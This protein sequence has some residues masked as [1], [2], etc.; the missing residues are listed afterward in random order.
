[1]NKKKNDYKNVVRNF[2]TKG[3]TKEALNFLLKNKIDEEQS[4]LLSARFLNLQKKIIK[5]VIDEKEANIEFNKVNESILNIIKA[6]QSTI[7]DKEKK[8]DD[9]RVNRGVKYIVLAACIVIGVSF[10]GYIFFFKNI[11]SKSFLLSSQPL[12]FSAE[13][14]ALKVLILPFKPDINSNDLHIDYKNQIKES[15]Q[16]KSDKEKLNVKLMVLDN[17]KFPTSDIEA[18]EVGETFKADIVIWGNFEENKL[19]PSGLRIRY[20]IIKETNIVSNRIIGDTEMQPLSNLRQIREGYLLN[21][22]DFI[23][24]WIEVRNAYR[25]GDFKSS[26]SKLNRILELIKNDTLEVETY[27]QLGQFYYEFNRG[28]DALK[29]F[30]KALA[31]QTTYLSP[32]HIDLTQTYASIC[33]AYNRIQNYE[34]AIFYCNKALEVQNNNLE[35]IEINPM[36]YRHL[37][38]LYNNKGDNKNAIKHHKKA[39]KV[40]EAILNSDEKEIARTYMNIGISFSNSNNDSAIFYIKKAM[41]IQYIVLDSLHPDLG[42]NYSNLASRLIIKGEYK[43]SYICYLEALRIQSEVLDSLHP[44]LASTYIGLA[45]SLMYQDTREFKLPLKYLQKALKIQRVTLDSLHPYLARTYINLG[46]LYS[47]KNQIDTS[48]IYYKRALNVQLSSLDSMHSDFTITYSSIGAILG[49]KKDYKSALKYL[50]KALEIQESNGLSSQLGI[51][52]MNIGA[53]ILYSKSYNEDEAL[54]YFDEA[55]NIFSQYPDKINMLLLD[56]NYS[57]YYLE[58][59]QFEK[60]LEL[61][62]KT[63]PQLR[64][65]YSKDH[66]NLIEAIEILD[67]LTLLTN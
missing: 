5:G 49:F 3:Q 35:P 29:C 7:T 12:P 26:I 11:N 31:A 2:I 41:E 4:V 59:C 40:Q 20:A 14:T 19:G 30:E 16:V 61:I 50:K 64:E 44:E 17:I 47:N 56:G 28:Q 63:I 53:I 62:E 67:E 23:I 15:L 48:L 13:E 51:I 57:R 8:N 25:N 32:L 65:I 38:N 58:T 55:K 39:L 42:R 36:T 60:A 45:V 37:G 33:S 54:S 43:Q 52:Y 6:K 27:M 22:I 1:M 21:D 66:P 24:Y 46:L 18:R 10:F 34:K 9:A